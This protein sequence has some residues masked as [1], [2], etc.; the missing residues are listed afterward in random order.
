MQFDYCVFPQK[1]K[2]EQGRYIYSHGDRMRTEEEYCSY[3]GL[4]EH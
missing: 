3:R 4:L 2:W 1:D